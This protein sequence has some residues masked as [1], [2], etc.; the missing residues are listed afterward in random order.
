MSA[1]IFARTMG[2]VVFVILNIC[3]YFLVSLFD[4]K[5][6]IAIYF[7]IFPLMFFVFFIISLLVSEHLL[8]YLVRK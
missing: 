8:N 4:N 5:P 3:S 6:Y 2:F 1:V 7:T